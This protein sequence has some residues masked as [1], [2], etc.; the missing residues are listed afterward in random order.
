MNGPLR[1]PL[2]AVINK[3]KMSTCRITTTWNTVHSEE[4]AT[5]TT[6]TLNITARMAK[7]LH[8]LLVRTATHKTFHSVYNI[9]CSLAVHVC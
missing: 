7:A 3:I 6:N 9:T 4:P 8:S 1:H 5:S 2:R